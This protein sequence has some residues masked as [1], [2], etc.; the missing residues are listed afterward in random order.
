MPGWAFRG[1]EGGG[2]RGVG[3]SQVYFV[4]RNTPRSAHF[5]AQGVR[6][7]RHLTGFSEFVSQA[8]QPCRVIAAPS[9]SAKLPEGMA[10]IFLSEIRHVNCS[11]IARVE[12]REI[13]NAPLDASQAWLLSPL[14]VT[15]LMMSAVVV[16]SYAHLGKPAEMEDVAGNL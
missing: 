9:K 15:G 13:R 8:R 11:A 6:S 5:I 4:T 1:A 2:R 12:S 7:S 14:T 10:Q 3:L 16:S